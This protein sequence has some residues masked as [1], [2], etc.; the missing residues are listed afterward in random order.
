[1]LEAQRVR[2]NALGDILRRSRGRNPN[3]PALYFEEEVLTYK[4]L[5][6]LANKTAHSLLSKGLQKGERVAVLSRNSMDF[7]ILNFGIAKSGAIMVPINFML[8]KEDVA[9]IFGH[10]EV[11]A[12]FAAP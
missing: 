12:C 10:A 8:N 9:Y 4:Q 6:Q 7:A 11:S 2:R 3:K 5:D 1:M